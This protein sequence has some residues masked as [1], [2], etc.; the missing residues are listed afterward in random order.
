MNVSRGAL[1]SFLLIFSI[2]ANAY[3]PYPATLI[4]VYDGD[5]FTVDIPIYPG[6]TAR[7]NIRAI[8]LDT[9][10][11]RG[12]TVCEKELAIKARDYARVLLTSGAIT[13]NNL[14]PD[15][16]PGRMDADVFINGR[17][18]ALDMIASGNGRTYSVGARLPWCI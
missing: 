12:S 17:S 5:T 8:G 13:V 3:G 11:I 1:G 18:F 2:L 4:S 7:T 15:T 9:P 14:K 16:Y 10:E 6:V